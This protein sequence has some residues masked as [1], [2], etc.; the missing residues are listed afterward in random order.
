MTQHK[1]T[2][3]VRYGRSAT[4]TTS[5]AYYLSANAFTSGPGAYGGGQSLEDS[6]WNT[7]KELTGEESLDVLGKERNKDDCNHHDKLDVSQALSI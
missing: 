5:D 2:Y 6:P 7:S 4:G 1:L 3:A